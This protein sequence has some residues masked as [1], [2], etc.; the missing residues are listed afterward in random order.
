MLYV[1]S[2]IS[3]EE[4]EGNVQFL[5]VTRRSAKQT[6]FQVVTRENC[7][8]IVSYRPQN[9]LSRT[10]NNFSDFNLL[11][12]AEDKV[13]NNI[14]LRLAYSFAKLSTFPLNI[15]KSVPSDK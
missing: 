7:D 9:I 4:A 13:L 12:I 1:N 5:L 6:W 15:K 2:Y 10:F 8:V 14:L 11:S 3:P